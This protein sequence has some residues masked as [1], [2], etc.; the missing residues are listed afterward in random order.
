MRDGKIHEWRD[1]FDA[2]TYSR[3]MSK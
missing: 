2:N 3:A 1:Y